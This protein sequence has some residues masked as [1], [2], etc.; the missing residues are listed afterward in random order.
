VSG[1]AGTASLS[2]VV[3]L[4][5]LLGPARD[6][7]AWGLVAHRMVNEEAIAAVPEPLRAFL[8]AHREELSDRAVEPDTILKERDGQREKVRHFI[9]LDLYGPAPFAALPHSQRA[10][11]ARYGREV[12]EERGTLPWTLL[13]MH[14]RLVGEMREGRWSDVVTT[15]GHAGHY[16]ADAFMPLH[17]TVNYDGQATGN[18][19]VHKAVEHELVDARIRGY[20]RAVR[21]RLGEAAKIPYGEEHV[22][23]LLVESYR[24]VPEI[25]AADEEARRKGTLASPRYLDAVD[26]RLRSLLVTQL[27]QATAELGVFWRSAWEE[28][29]RPQPPR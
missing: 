19:G 21:S 20:R 29:G 25:L 26:G 11:V 2:S 17:T 8:R 14:G 7:L 22:F 1:R 16:V 15:A 24:H 18:A 9:D 10:A 6:A 13:E 27:T 23:A 5:L 4:T 12:V 28:A 3:A